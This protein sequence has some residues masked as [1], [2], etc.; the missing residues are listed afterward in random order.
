MMDLILTYQWEILIVSEVLSWVFLLLFGVAR[1]FFDKRRLGF[2]FIVLFIALIAFE[3]IIGWLIYQE[4]GKISNSQIIITVFVLYAVTFGVADFKKLDRWMRKQI[5][6]WRNVELLTEKDIKIIKTEKNPKYI[7]RKYRLSSIIH[8]LI[9]VAVQVVFWLHGSGSTQVILSYA[10]DLSWIGTSNIAETPYA[11]ETIYRIS[12]V[13]GIVF[14]IDF[15]YSW[16]Y[17]LFP[18]NSKGGLL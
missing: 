3:A 9:F 8:F 12:M 2:T 13:W 10:K 15:I 4:T 7:A 5:G 11:N 16:S 6:N 14:I 17:T 1:Y 18:S